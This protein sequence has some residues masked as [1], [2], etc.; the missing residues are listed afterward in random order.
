MPRPPEEP[1]PDAD[2]APA[3]AA[4]PAPASAMPETPAVTASEPVT[5]E[6]TPADS[7]SAEP[8]SAEPAPGEPAPGEPAV[9]PVLALLRGRRPLP[10]D[11]AEVARERRRRR[12]RRRRSLPANN[13]PARRRSRRLAKILRPLQYGVLALLSVGLMAVAVYYFASDDELVDAEQISQARSIQASV[14]T[15]VRQGGTPSIAGTA[16]INYEALLARLLARNPRLLADKQVQRAFANRYA[17]DEVAATVTDEFNRA[18]LYDREGREMA[19]IAARSGGS[20]ITFTILVQLRLGEYDFATQSFPVSV[21]P[22]FHFTVNPDKTLAGRPV[23]PVRGGLPSSFEVNIPD[24]SGFVG[25]PMGPDEA[26]KFLAG[27]MVRARD[28]I[29]MEPDRRLVAEISYRIADLTQGDPTGNLD[30]GPVYNVNVAAEMV[31]FRVFADTHGP[32]FTADAETLSARL[33]RARAQYERSP[34]LSRYELGVTPGPDGIV[35]LPADQLPLLHAAL[36]HA[37]L[38]LDAYLDGLPT[39]QSLVRFS[40]ERA[41]AAARLRP[42][43]ERIALPAVAAPT[44][45]RRVRVPMLVAQAASASAFATLQPVNHDDLILVDELGGV[46][47]GLRI[48]PR[49]PA[50]LPAPV[51]ERAVA[52]NGGARVV[53]TDLLLAPTG[54]IVASDDTHIVIALLKAIE[55]HDGGGKL[56]VAR[57]DVPPPPEPAAR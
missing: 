9:D 6:T 47:Y 13:L 53:T 24:I 55:F 18:E 31:G 25:L 51:A 34:I 11:P 12:R 35:P 45:V 44:A 54:G 5:P 21:P 23:C 4:H 27:R 40:P 16:L 28:N 39:V 1:A 29:H 37:A 3:D 57:F 48:D 36:T 42:L 10:P 50:Q 33:L 56:V 38:P 30:G 22:R 43:M 26:H 41:A 46:R 15:A 32:I 49:T 2:P 20:D 19:T 8:T 14:P 52:A 17:C 7:T